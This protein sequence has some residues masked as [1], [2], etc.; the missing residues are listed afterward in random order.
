MAIAMRMRTEDVMA[1]PYR[2]TRC[3]WLAAATL[4]SDMRNRARERLMPGGRRQ[5]G[6][7]PC[8]FAA[9]WRSNV[10]VHE[11]RAQPQSPVEEER[12]KAMAGAV[13][14]LA[15]GSSAVAF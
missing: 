13:G 10:T 4:R 12:M 5:S 14:V 9:P 8:N 1:S 7:E 15:I 6:S 11:R 2:P 3:L